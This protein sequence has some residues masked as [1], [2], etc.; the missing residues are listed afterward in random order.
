[1]GRNFKGVE[2]LSMCIDADTLSWFPD[3][4]Q[5][6]SSEFHVNSRS[7]PLHGERPTAANLIFINTIENLMFYASVKM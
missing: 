6:Y 1:M 7:I 5:L 3:K 2:L 4:A